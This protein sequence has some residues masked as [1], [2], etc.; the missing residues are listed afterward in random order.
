MTMTYIVDNGRVYSDHTLYF[1]DVEA[2]WWTHFREDLVFW[3]K[4]WTEILERYGDN[5]KHMQPHA[6]ALAEALNERK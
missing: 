6:R 5:A 2:A 4:R 1:I 3:A